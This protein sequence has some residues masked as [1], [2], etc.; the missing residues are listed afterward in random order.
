MPSGHW[1][2]PTAAL[3]ATRIGGQQY[4]NTDVREVS[5]ALK[6]ATRSLPLNVAS[7]ALATGVPG[8]TIRQIVS[9]L[10]GRLMLIGKRSN[11]L[12]VCHVADEGDEYTTALERHWRS[13]RDRVTRRRS[14]ARQLPRWQQHMF[15]GDP[16][17]AYEED[18]DDD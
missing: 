18:E 13:E 9:D 1:W 4:T 15:D 16:A 8:R 6:P 14:F 3:D 10:D 5:A 12:F 7:I 17:L 11:G 2:Q